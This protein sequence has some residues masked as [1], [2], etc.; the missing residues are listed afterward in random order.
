MNNIF[1]NQYKLFNDDDNYDFIVHHKIMVYTK[2]TSTINLPITFYNNIKWKYINNLILPYTNNNYLIPYLQLTNQN[3][4]DYISS[5]YIIPDDEI[6][7]GEKIQYLADIV[8][9]TH[10]SLHWNP[11]NL[12]FS[13]NIDDI[14]RI[15]NINCYNSIFVFTHDLDYIN[16]FDISNKILISHNSDHEINK[17]Y[18]AKLH[19][20]QNCLIKHNNLI[21]IPIGIENKQWFD[22]N[23]L[24]QVRHMNIPKT[25]NIY[26]FFN[27]NTHPSRQNCFNKLINTL[28]FNTRRNKKDY[29]IELA[30]HKYAVCPRGNGLDTHRIWEC[31]YLNVI[32]III[33]NDSVNI[34]D[35]PI[36]ILNDW[37]DI[38]S[39]TDEFYNIKLSKLTISYYKNLII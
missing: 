23:I 29:F 33:Q 8:L 36:N 22:H 28:E 10:N 38:N 9:G 21:P 13:K 17:N 25:K 18:N 1:I 24:F 35:L 27:L 20:A 5:A 6:I 31:L 11:N 34:D 7:S 12:E 26:F 30:K 14:N 4:Y 2:I 19:L 32:P 15:N 39:I 3:P 37:N 16:N